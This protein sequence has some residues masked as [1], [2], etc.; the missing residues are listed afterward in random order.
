M[1]SF[2]YLCSKPVACFSISILAGKSS[3]KLFRITQMNDKS[4]RAN[5][6]RFNE[7]MLDAEDFIEPITS[8]ALISGVKE[9][10][11]VEEVICPTR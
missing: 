10:N 4:T 11:L 5:L 6:K 2:N 7:K 1:T 8:K 3:A 9:K